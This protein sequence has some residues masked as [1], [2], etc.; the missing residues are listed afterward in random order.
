MPRTMVAPTLIESSPEQM[1][2]RATNPATRPIS[3][4][5]IMKPSMTC[6]PFL[7]GQR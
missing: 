7:D 6:Y 1:M 3:S 4:M 5:T 2:A